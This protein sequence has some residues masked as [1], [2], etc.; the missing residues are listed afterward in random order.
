MEACRW[1]PDLRCKAVAHL[2]IIRDKE[3]HVVLVTDPGRIFSEP[4]I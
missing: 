1:S 2:R 4:F 3:V